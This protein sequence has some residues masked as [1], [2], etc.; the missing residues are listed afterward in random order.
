M[1]YITKGEEPLELQR[2]KKTPGVCFDNMDSDTKQAVK[3]SLLNEQGHICCYCGRRIDLNEHTILE[4]L[5]PRGIPQYRCLELNYDNILA[6]CDGG[7]EERA[8]GN[9][10]FPLHCDSKKEN[11]ILPISPLE[12]D[13]KSCF[14]FDEDGVIYPSKENDTDAKETIRILGLDNSYLNHCRKAAIDAYRDLEQTTEEWDNDLNRLNRLFDNELIEFCFVV[15]NY[16]EFYK[17]PLA[18]SL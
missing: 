11:N 4:H 6:S 8:N 17:L 7:Q 18:A 13:C 16:I 2:Y 14:I 10:R 15:E 1:R 9:K 5:L 3:K 12:Q